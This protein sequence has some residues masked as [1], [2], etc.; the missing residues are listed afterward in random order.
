MDTIKRKTNIKILS[1]LEFN[2][3]GYESLITDVEFGDKIMSIDLPDGR[4]FTVGQTVL[5][6]KTPYKI[7]MID[8]CCFYY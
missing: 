7:N 3:N 5:L 8:L 1:P 4:N 6:N 2:V